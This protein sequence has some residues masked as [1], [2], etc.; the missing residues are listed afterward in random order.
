MSI[1][2]KTSADVHRSHA[3]APQSGGWLRRRGEVERRRGG[4]AERRRGGE[5]WRSRGMRDG[6]EKEVVRIW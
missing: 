2:T 4:E 5:E 3:P 1:N 6:G